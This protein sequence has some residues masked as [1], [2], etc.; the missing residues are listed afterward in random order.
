M[1]T[2]DYP[3]RNYTELQKSKVSI[4]DSR[5]TY[6]DTTSGTAF[7][8]RTGEIQKN[9]IDTKTL[10][11]IHWTA[12]TDNNSY[13]SEYSS[14]YKKLPSATRD[15]S[16]SRDSMMRTHFS[17]GNCPTEQ[18]VVTRATTSSIPHR[19]NLRDQMVST[20][21]D[22]KDPSA[23]KWRTSNQDA[24]YK[25]ASGISAGR[26][27]NSIL[28]GSGAKQCFQCAAAF[29]PTK[30]L[31]SDTYKPFS[32]NAFIRP[33][34]H[35]LQRTTFNLGDTPLQYTTT[36]G[37]DMKETAAAVRNVR[38]VDP[39]Y[40]TLQRLALTKSSVNSG[41]DFPS[42]KES[43]MHAGLV[44]Y[45]NFKPPKPVE[46]SATISHHDFR[47]WNGRPSTTQSEAF[48][49]KLSQVDRS[50]A[51]NN[52]L[53]DSH[54]QIGTGKFEETT[55]LYQDTFKQFKARP[56]LADVSKIR[57]FHMGTHSKGDTN[58]A[59]TG[60]TTN[61][62]TYTGCKGGKASK[63][64]DSLKGGNNIVPNEP[65][66]VVSKSATHTDYVAHPIEHQQAVNNKLQR[67]HIKLDGGQGN[68]TTTQ[69]DYFQFKTYKMPEAKA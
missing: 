60:K 49:P 16:I 53:Q 44:P 12:G 54:M 35:N 17:L 1:Y 67:S 51:V 19:E 61:Q 5:I 64:C 65:R 66:F 57:E 30:S 43:S 23:P 18:R 47:N 68:W 45:P 27:D 20:H 10:Q 62:E 37:D 33:V 8:Q 39:H 4:G 42:V 40:A 13:E 52:R 36:T 32:K 69:S 48:T 55:S 6:Y 38:P 29:G 28:T 46:A 11:R 41:H 25:G 14:Q 7:C 59:K 22:L 31:N 26:V 63:I 2:P 58:L 56:E 24:F 15:S 9:Q 34:T 21:F 50:Q 3:Q